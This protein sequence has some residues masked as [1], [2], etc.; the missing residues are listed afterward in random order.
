MTR[1]VTTQKDRAECSPV[2]TEGSNLAQQ[3]P[4]RPG[5]TCSPSCFN[6]GAG[7]PP[8]P[9]HRQMAQPWALRTAQDASQ[10]SSLLLLWPRE[11]LANCKP[12]GLLW[13][14]PPTPS[15]PVRGRRGGKETSLRPEFAL[16]CHVCPRGQPWLCPILSS[17][18]QLPGR[19]DGCT[20]PGRQLQTL[21]S[22]AG[23]G[24]RRGNMEWGVGE[25]QSS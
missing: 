14:L 9:A 20:T 10:Q 25:L 16:L 4:E 2:S 19:I 8:P 24:Q 15:D 1:A 12:S 13:V 17:G 11:L 18:A 7:S 21:Q 6:Q 3:E 5:S 22:Q 23:R